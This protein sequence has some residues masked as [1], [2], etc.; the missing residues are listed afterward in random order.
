[1]SS[2][3]HAVRAHRSE[4][5]L[6][7]IFIVLPASLTVSLSPR[8]IS[9][10]ILSSGQQV[11]NRFM[12]PL[13]QGNP[14]VDLALLFPLDEVGPQ[15][16]GHLLGMLKSRQDLWVLWRQRGIVT[17][18]R[19][20]GLLRASEDTSVAFGRICIST[21]EQDMMWSSRGQGKGESRTFK[22]NP[23]RPH[24][25]SVS[26]QGHFERSTTVQEQT[27]DGA[28]RIPTSE[29]RLLSRTEVVPEFVGRRN[30]S[31]RPALIGLTGFSVGLP[32]THGWIKRKKLGQFVQKQCPSTFFLRHLLSAVSPTRPQ[33]QP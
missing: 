7:S 25:I 23:R 12:E 31:C 13:V 15:E 29:Y 21:R 28:Q 5:F 17:E 1:M 11:S 32:Q 14:T 6:P 30:R 22:G 2:L 33:Q 10:C 26:L 27:G 9:S 8:S 4:H 3:Y 24:K 16:L 18:G 19:S 20:N